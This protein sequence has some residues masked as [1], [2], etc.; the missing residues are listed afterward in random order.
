VRI[1]LDQEPTVWGVRP[2]A[3]PLFRSAAEVFG[4]RTVGVVLTGMGKDGAEGLRDIVGAGG[5]GIAQDKASS[6]IYGM[7]A[8]AARIASEVLP[9]DRIH[10]GIERGVDARPASAPSHAAG[11]H[12]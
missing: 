7:P 6:V 11:H 2:A 4:A 3:D 1:A 5:H 8:A 12:A 9:L 10:T